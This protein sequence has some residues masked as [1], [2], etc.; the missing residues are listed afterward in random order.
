M[1]MLKT[2]KNGYFYAGDFS[3]EYNLTGVGVK[4]NNTQAEF[5]FIKDG[6]LN[7]FGIYVDVTGKVLFGELKPDNNP[8]I[9]VTYNDGKYKLECTN[10]YR[11]LGI[12]G[13]FNETNFGIIDEYDACAVWYTF[14]DE[15]L[16]IRDDNYE[17]ASFY[18]PGFTNMNEVR[19]LLKIKYIPSSIYDLKGGKVEED[20]LQVIGE[21]TYTFMKIKNLY[22][23]GVYEPNIGKFRDFHYFVSPDGVLYQEFAKNGD[24]TGLCI[25]SNN[26]KIDISY[27][28]ENKN[29]GPQF[30]FMNDSKD[31]F[32]IIINRNGVTKKVMALRD[33]FSVVIYDDKDNVIAKY[34]K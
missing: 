28:I 10:G 23:L 19:R 33:D 18:L 7:G 24:T 29:D 8:K 30:W 16:H 11:P 15:T 6:V 34:S 12:R 25:N 22:A 20:Y 3:S 31:R 27:T 4:S 9:T 1:A 2:N 5:G 17:E 21:D 13:F 32:K 26:N 14:A